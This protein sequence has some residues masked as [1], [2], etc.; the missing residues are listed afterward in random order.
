MAPSY[1]F[2]T[3]G[4]SLTTMLSIRTLTVDFLLGEDEL[5]ELIDFLGE[6]LERLLLED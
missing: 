6:L 3:F 5:K 1:F 2:E 4:K